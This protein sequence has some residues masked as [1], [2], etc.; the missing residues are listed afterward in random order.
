MRSI[1]TSD[2]LDQSQWMHTRM[3]SIAGR[4][5]ASPAT[6]MK[7][8]KLT[9]EL[10]EAYKV[11]NTIKKQPSSAFFTGSATETLE[12]NIVSLYG[13]VF[14]AW[15]KTEVTHIQH[16]AHALESSIQTGKVTTKNTEKLADHIRA[17]K[18]DCCPSISDRRILAEAEL[19]T[20]RAHAFLEGSPLP[21]Q[22]S[23]EDLGEI[24]PGELEDLMDL[25][26]SLYKY[27][28]R[29]AKSRFAQLPQEH[30]RMI[31]RHLQTLGANPFEDA[32]EMIQ[33][34][35]ATVNELSQNG[36]GYPSK[37][38]IDDLF[39]GLAQLDLEVS[40]TKVFSLSS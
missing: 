5:E 22:A 7:F 38:E 6:P 34:C 26:A 15:I 8:H 13:R 37:E 24:F 35:I 2:F 40:G 17:F 4:L 1:K 3:Q 33:A 29:Q 32:V 28:F 18:Q 9:T 21:V 14:N 25:A 23:P 31:N 27:D 20:V 39:M 10:D 11:L 30:K 16:E 12:Q 36:E 19:T